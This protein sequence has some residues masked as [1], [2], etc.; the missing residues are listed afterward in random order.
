MS[1]AL[2]DM[3]ASIK[4]LQDKL[5]TRAGNTAINK[6]LLQEALKERDMWLMILPTLGRQSK[7]ATGS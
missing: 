3:E 7:Q 2:E 5:A 4:E 1:T 6:A